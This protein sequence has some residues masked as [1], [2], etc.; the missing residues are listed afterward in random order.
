MCEQ[1]FRLPVLFNIQYLLLVVFSPNS[2][3]TL[4]I[5]IYVLCTNT[6]TAF[7]IFLHIFWL[8][9][10]NYILEHT[11]KLLHYIAHGIMFFNNCDYYWLKVVRSKYHLPTWKYRFF[12][13]LFKKQIKLKKKT[14]NYI[15]TFIVFVDGFRLT[16]V[17]VDYPD[18]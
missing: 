15:K 10:I 17:D 11:K 8:H 14:Q 3:N 13:C 9:C 16:C 6:P 2:L 7:V 4:L 1:E 5:I 12:F 18:V